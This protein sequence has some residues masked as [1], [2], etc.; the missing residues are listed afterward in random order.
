MSDTAVEFHPS[1]I[2]IEKEYDIADE[3][4]AAQVAQEIA[5]AWSP[6]KATGFKVRMPK[7]KKIAKRMGYTVMT[8]VNYFL[9]K[10]GTERNVRYWVYHE[11]DSHYAIVL[12]DARSLESLDL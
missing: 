3:E 5:L 11:D 1:K 4:S 8:T 6:D 7:E 12:I 2:P 10:S 9:R